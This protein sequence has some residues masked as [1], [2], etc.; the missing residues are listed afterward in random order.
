MS[1]RRTSVGCVYQEGLWG[2]VRK[3]T[4]PEGHFDFPQGGMEDIDRSLTGTVIREMKEEIGEKHIF[5][6]VLYTGIWTERP[7]SPA[8]DNLAREYT[9]KELHYFFMPMEKD[10]YNLVL[11]DNLVESKLVPTNRLL[12]EIRDVSREKVREVLEKLRGFNYLKE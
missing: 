9:G 10:I 6:D 11:G 3:A 8:A 2:L 5:I 1:F 4:W 7:F 12:D